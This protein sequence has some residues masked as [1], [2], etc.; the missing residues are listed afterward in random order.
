MLAWREKASSKMAKIM[1]VEPTTV[2]GLLFSQWYEPA[3]TMHIFVGIR[4]F[5]LN[6]LA[7]SQN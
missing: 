4:D 1:R 5:Q 7:S 2:P 6:K 3:F